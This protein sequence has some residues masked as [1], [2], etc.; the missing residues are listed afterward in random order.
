MSLTIEI[1]LIDKLSKATS[2]ASVDTLLR[3]IATSLLPEVRFRIHN[4]GLNASASPI[5]TY[6]PEYLKKRIKNGKTGNPKVVLS[7]TRQMQNDFKVIPMQQSYGLGFSNPD[8][9]NKAE[10]AQERFGLIYALTPDEIK[11]MQLIIDD[12]LEKT[13]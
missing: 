10:W 3:S 11:K 7:Y 12:W 6:S 5:G 13:L 2:P 4:K 1:P 8:D 9:T